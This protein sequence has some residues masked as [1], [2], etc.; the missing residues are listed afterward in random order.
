MKNQDP[1]FLLYSADFLVGTMAFTDDQVGKYVRILCYQHQ[2]GFIEP[3]VMRRLCGGIE[4]LMILAKFKVSAEGFYYNQ[5]LEDERVKRETHKKRQSDNAA[6]RWHKSGIKPASSRHIPNPYQT[7]AKPMPL[8]DED[9]NTVVLKHTAYTDIEKQQR[10]AE[11]DVVAAAAFSFLVE[12][13]AMDL[14][15]AQVIFNNHKLPYIQEKIELTKKR[16]EAGHLENAPGFFLAALARN[17]I[18]NSDVGQ[19]IKQQKELA[20]E[21][22]RQAYIIKIESMLAAG[23]LIPQK[24]YDAL[25][26][27]RREELTHDE[28]YFKQNKDWAYYDPKTRGGEVG[29]K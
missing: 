16:I 14:Q 18:D 7:H 28:E 15:Q 26:A 2:H 4:D 29:K 8:E 13:L 25:P 1:A 19:K 9:V 21:K 27:I 23:M 22:A 17:F 6:M 5:R 11:D 24:A 12:T 3:E 20:K 10:Q